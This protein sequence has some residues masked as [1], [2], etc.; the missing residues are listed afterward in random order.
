MTPDCSTSCA[1]GAC[2]DPRAARG[3]RRAR[4]AAAAVRVVVSPAPLPPAMMAVLGVPVPR[5]GEER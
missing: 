5:A 4:A 1:C 2:V 3:V